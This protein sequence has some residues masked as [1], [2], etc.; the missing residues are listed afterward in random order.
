MCCNTVVYDFYGGVSESL[1][2]PIMFVLCGSSKFVNITINKWKV[3]IVI[4]LDKPIIWT[5]KFM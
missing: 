2:K 4:K 3:S 5:V 1:I